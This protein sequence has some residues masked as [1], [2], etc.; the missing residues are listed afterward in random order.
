MQATA[1]EVLGSSWATSGGFPVPKKHN[2]VASS[3]SAGASADNLTD[4][5]K[6]DSMRAASRLLTTLQQTQ[7]VRLSCSLSHPRTTQPVSVMHSQAADQ[8]VQPCNK[9]PMQSWVAQQGLVLLLV[10]P[11]LLLLLVCQE[12]LPEGLF[13]WQRGNLASGGRQAST[14]HQLCRAPVN[15]M[16]RNTQTGW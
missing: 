4:L 1:R 7:V 13:R 14:G 11:S 16:W 9:L 10:L 2:R 8:P 6:V 12:A 3:S 5:L 15:N